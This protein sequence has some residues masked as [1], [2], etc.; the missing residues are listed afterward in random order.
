[1]QYI[2][3]IHEYVYEY[4]A[5]YSIVLQNIVYSTTHLDRPLFYLN[6]FNSN[7][8]DVLFQT[9]LKHMVHVMIMPGLWTVST[10][11]PEGGEFVERG[12]PGEVLLYCVYSYYTPSHNEVV[13]RL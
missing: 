3:P 11:D 6:I 2:Q 5:L 13:R 8:V 10:R 7:F 1:M 9:Y 12:C 4:A